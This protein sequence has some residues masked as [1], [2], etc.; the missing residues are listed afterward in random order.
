MKKTIKTIA[1]AAIV[2]TAFACS[3]EVELVQDT[4][5][6]SEPKFVYTFAIA[7]DDEMTKSILGSD[8]DGKFAQW[9]SGDFL[10]S[11]TNKTGYSSITPASGETPATFNISSSSAL[12]VDDKITVWFPYDSN[13]IPL[14]ATAVTLTIPAEQYHFSD[15]SFNFD[16]MPMVTKQI[17]VDSDIV[18]LYNSTSKQTPLSTIKFSYLGTVINFRVFSTNPTY[19]SEK[20][21]SITFNA[22]NS[23]NSADATIAG[24]F[25]KNLATINPDES[26]PSTML[27]PEF[28]TSVSSVTTN[29][30][31]DTAIGSDKASA[32]NLYMVV[33][34]GT[35]TGTVLVTTNAARYSFPISSAKNLARSGIKAFGLDLNSSNATRT[36]LP[37]QVYSWE[38]TAVTSLGA[39]DVFVIVGDTGSKKFALTNDKGTSANPSVSSVTISG[40][41]ISSEVA[42]N[43]QWRIRGNAAAGYTFYPQNDDKK[44]FYCNTTASSS[45]NT[46]LRVGTG[47]RKAFVLDNSNYLITKDSYTTR[48]VS[49]YDDSD[50]RSYV[51]TDNG[52][53]PIAFYKKVSEDAPSHS[54]TINNTTPLLGSVSTS[55][56]GTAYENAAVTVTG[57]PEDGYALSSVTVA[58]VVVSD[59]V[60]NQ[61]SFTMPTSDVTVTATFAQLYTIT[62]SGAD[63]HG[64]VEVLPATSSLADKTITITATANTGYVFD[65]WSVTGATPASTTTNPTTFTMPSGN[66]T[67]VANFRSAKSDP[68]L[69]FEDPSYTFTIGDDDYNAFIG[70]DL[71]NPNNVSP[72]VWTSSNENLATVDGGVVEFVTSATG[73]T[74]IRASFAGDST[75]E[76]DYAEYTIKVK[77]DYS[78]MYTSNATMSA[79]DNSSSAIVVINETNYEAIKCGTT[80]KAGVATVSVPSG[81][82]KLHVHIAGWNGEGVKT[83][84]ITPTA[85]ISKINGASSTSITDTADSGISNNSPFTLSGTTVISSSYYYE[86]DLTGISSNTTITFTAHTK[87][88][89]RF[90]IWGCNAE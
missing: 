32:L 89:N 12:D 33:A 7:N 60:N 65:N 15:G 13:N 55:P 1:F 63:S 38:E 61:C 25:V 77:P 62:A 51:N 76:V 44:W 80:S 17:T 10:G 26:E 45:S 73:Q 42:D 75:Y 74:T 9:K 34:P 78:T 40:T 84:D 3:K 18:D 52:A 67:V 59:I 21:R 54:I 83:I 30:Y 19:A 46:N 48:Y 85:K 16:A 37:P 49:I 11:I 14:S 20:V 68:N 66:V 41:T 69:S 79:G 50:W 88:N 57:E 5:N 8:A 6:Y 90:V 86:I 87:S 81:T 43:I 22:R 35:Y 39:S 82:T 29:T 23:D 47:D 36:P 72:I 31:T 24:S 58:G 4:V 56:S 53:C 64:T 2:F 28:A 27:I 70:Q 71:V